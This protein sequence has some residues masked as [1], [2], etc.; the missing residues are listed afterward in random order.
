MFMILRIVSLR[1]DSLTLKGLSQISLRW[2]FGVIKGTMSMPRRASLLETGISCSYQGRLTGK[3]KRLPSKVR[4]HQ[5]IQARTSN[6]L[7]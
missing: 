4:M 6:R 5:Q 1:T 3:M 7:W 2:V